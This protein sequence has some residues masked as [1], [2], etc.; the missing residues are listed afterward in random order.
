M[1]DSTTEDILTRLLAQEHVLVCRE[2]HDLIVS[3]Q[4][5]VERLE[6]ER[7]AAIQNRNFYAEERKRVRAEE[8]EAC[9]AICEQYVTP[10][11]RAGSAPDACEG[12]ARKLAA[13]IRARGEGAQVEHLSQPSPAEWQQERERLREAGW[14]VAVHNDYRLNG[15]PH[16][17][18]LFTHPSGR[19]IKGE[20]RTDE[21]ALNECV[22]EALAAAAPP[23]LSELRHRLSE[24]KSKHRHEG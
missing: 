16:T 7:D 19:W 24:D 21:I 2:A 6:A 3:L 14:M 9:A 18:W 13:V 4:G 5:E 1:T 8:R 12:T 23:P 17:F 22:R 11:G 20:G 10:Y 15:E